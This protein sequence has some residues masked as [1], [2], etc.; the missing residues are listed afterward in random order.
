MCVIAET[1]YIRL[2]NRFYTQVDETIT[3]GKLAQ[4][5][6]PNQLKDQIC[7]LPQYTITKEDSSYVVIDAMDVIDTIHTHFPHVDIQTVGPSQTVLEV[8]SKK[9]KVRPLF[10]SLVWILLFIGAALTIMNFHED[11]A[12]GDV[13]QKIYQLITGE[14]K[15]K[16]LII[17]I[18]YSLGVGIGMVLFFN[19]LFKKKFNEEPSPLE[20]EIF[21]YQQDL[22]QFIVIQEKR[23]RETKPDVD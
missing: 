16:P 10:I 2:R 14:K 4:V 1:I 11:V 22:D 17:Q 20:V 13:H 7:R 19:H 5:I 8:K 9:R 12:M 23:K 3:I 18:P 15:E 21:K 6:A